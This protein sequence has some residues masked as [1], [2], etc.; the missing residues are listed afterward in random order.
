MS[1]QIHQSFFHP[2][3]FSWPFRLESSWIV[4]MSLYLLLKSCLKLEY[5]IWNVASK[6]Y[7]WPFIEGF[8]SFWIITTNKHIFNQEEYHMIYNRVNIYSNQLHCT[9]W[10]L[11]LKGAISCF[12]TDNELASMIIKLKM[13]YRKAGQDFVMDAHNYNSNVTKDSRLENK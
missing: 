2:W 9:I 4:V 7:T 11:F 10:N 8:D 12:C 1:C 5:S 6:F 13:S 3:V